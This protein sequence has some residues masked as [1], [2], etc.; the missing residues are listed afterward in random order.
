MRI[1]FWA[2]GQGDCSCITFDD[3]EYILI[4]TGPRFSPIVN[5]FK[6]RTNEGIVTIKALVI[7]HNHVDHCGA[8]DSLLNIPGLNIHQIFILSNACKASNN[9]LKE[10]LLPLFEDAKYIHKVAIPRTP[11]TIWEDDTRSIVIVAPT[12]QTQASESDV[13]KGSMILK[14]T[15]KTKQCDEFMWGGDAFYND[16]L[17]HMKPKAKLLMGPH[18]GAPQDIPTNVCPYCEYLF[19]SLSYKNCKQLHPNKDYIHNSVNAGISI[20]CTCFTKNCKHNK[21]LVH[22]L[23]V[24]HISP[25]EQPKSARSFKESVYCRGGMYFTLIDNNWVIDDNETDY[26]SKKEQVFNRL[27]KL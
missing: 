13:N 27:C 2:V 17:P 19:V 6:Q 25:E 18:H 16:L 4:D 12:W 9:K 7:T 1:D 10:C 14:L 21:T 24:G 8:L 5:W 20:A 22:P 26:L 11:E 3:G 15:N 23:E